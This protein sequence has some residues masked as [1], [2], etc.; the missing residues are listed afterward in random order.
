MI[1]LIDTFLDAT[2]DL[3]IDLWLYMALGFLVGAWSRNLF[4]RT[5]S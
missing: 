3:L 5:R 4:P 2:R 1:G